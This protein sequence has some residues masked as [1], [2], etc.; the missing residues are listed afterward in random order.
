M[1]SCRRGR[2]AAGHPGAQPR[3]TQRPQVR[4]RPCVWDLAGP[5]AWL[6][7][8]QRVYRLQA[9]C[10]AWHGATDIPTTRAHVD[11]LL[12]SRVFSL[13]VPGVSAPCP[14]ALCPLH[15]LLHP[16]CAPLAPRSQWFSP[17]MPE[18][19]MEK[20]RFYLDLP[21]DFWESGT[22]LRYLREREVQVRTAGPLWGHRVWVFMCVCVCGGGGLFVA[23]GVAASVLHSCWLGCLRGIMPYDLRRTN[24]NQPTHTCFGTHACV[25]WLSLRPDPVGRQ[26]P[27]VHPALQAP[28][29]AG[30]SAHRWV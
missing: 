22:L 6:N 16:C 14:D 23:G 18:W 8:T 7:T 13:H 24:P 10:L 19:D 4:R 11:T 17:E 26:Q 29:Q 27:A 21:G 25:C 30:R 28:H 15:P 20:Y 3:C 5:R 2:L 12:P 9:A 1:L